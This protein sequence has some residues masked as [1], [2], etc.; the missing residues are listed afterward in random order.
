MLGVEANVLGLFEQ[1][2]GRSSCSPLGA[3][4]A[5]AT[6]GNRW[7][8]GIWTVGGRAGIAAGMWM[9]YVAGG[10]AATRVSNTGYNA[11]GAIVESFSQDRSGW[12]AGVGVD[13]AFTPNWIAGLE[14][15][16]YD[17]ATARGIP[18][19]AGGVPVPADTTDLKVKADTVVARLSYKFGVAGPVV[20][21][22]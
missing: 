6:I 2:L 8:D 7:G 14:Y 17:F 4:A 15:R 10:Y 16:H 3:C 21:K 11:A 12:Y 5:G 20:A 18:I 22:Y 19:I 1:D 9:P 13:Y